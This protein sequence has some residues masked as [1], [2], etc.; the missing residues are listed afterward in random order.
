MC[1]WS[2]EH[3]TWGVRCGS[4]HGICIVVDV[5]SLIG[6]CWWWVPIFHVGRLQ[7]GVESCLVLGGRLSYVLSYELQ[8][9]FTTRANCQLCVLPPCYQHYSSWC[10]WWL[11]HASTR[12]NDPDVAGSDIL[13]DS[14]NDS[15]HERM[16]DGGHRPPHWPCHP[17]S[18]KMHLHRLFIQHQGVNYRRQLMSVN[19]RYECVSYWCHWL[20][21]TFDPR[22]KT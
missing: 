11:H 1:C 21:Y 19:W 15:L 17:I 9:L 7:R 18:I 12:S 16:E 3:R 13:L 5:L 2:W 22:P 20:G 10:H 4:H 14:V 8:L 6:S